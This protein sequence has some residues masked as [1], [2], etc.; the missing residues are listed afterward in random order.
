MDSWQVWLWSQ[1]G[2]LVIYGKI[3]GAFTSVRWR[4]IWKIGDKENG[5]NMVKSGIYLYFPQFQHFYYS[6]V[7]LNNNLRDI[8]I[9][10]FLPPYRSVL[11]L[12]NIKP[13]NCIRCNLYLCRNTIKEQLG[14]L[15]FSSLKYTLVWEF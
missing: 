6:D 5:R 7:V 8:L 9:L 13:V 14:E 15:I 3:T 4:N 12:S 11:M 10:I 2:K 1:L